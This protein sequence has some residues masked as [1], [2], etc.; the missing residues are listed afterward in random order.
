M[1]ID[2]QLPLTFGRAL[3]SAEYWLLLTAALAAGFG[4]SAWLTIPATM[5]G[6]LV[7]SLPK[8]VLHYGRAR[9]VGAVAAFWY[10]ITASLFNAAIAAVAATLAG[11]FTW[12]L[13]G[14]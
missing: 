2:D 6:L 1:G 8:Y 3:R 11:R 13:W 9:E 14:L 4:V 12:W 7:S 5:A 10:T